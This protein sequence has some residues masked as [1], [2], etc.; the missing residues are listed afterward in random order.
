MDTLRKPKDI[1]W[2][3]R[4]SQQKERST[5]KRSLEEVTDRRNKIAQL[6]EEIAEA[7]RDINSTNQ[8]LELLR[9]IN[10]LTHKTLP[11]RPQLSNHYKPSP[12]MEEYMAL[13]GL[14][15]GGAIGGAVYLI[16]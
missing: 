7:N 12:E 10:E 2:L 16:L 8:S 3:W 6:R 4:P 14:L 13:F 9:R 1:T 5:L 15:A 11:K